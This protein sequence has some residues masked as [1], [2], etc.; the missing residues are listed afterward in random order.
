M[1]KYREK[2]NFVVLNIKVFISYSNK[3]ISILLLSSLCCTTHSF[4]LWM[5]LCQGTAFI[6]TCFLHYFVQ[7][8][9][10]FSCIK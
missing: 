1:N 10:S 8:F 2:V 9:A 5:V 6:K 4:G 7:S 3:V